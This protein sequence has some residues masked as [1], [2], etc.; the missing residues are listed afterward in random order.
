MPSYFESLSM[1]ALEAW[2]LGTP[3][4]RQREMRRAE[5]SVHPQQRRAVLRR[6]SRVRRN[7]ARDRAQSLAGRQPRQERPPVL[8][9]PLRLAGHR[10]EVSRHDRAAVE[11]RR[12]RERSTPV[13]GWFERRKV[14]C[15]PGAEVVA[16]LPSGPVDSA[17]A[18]AA[19]A[20]RRR[21]RR[22]SR[23]GAGRRAI[24]SIA[25]RDRR[26]AAVRRRR[27]PL[28]RRAAAR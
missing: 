26:H 13:P 25:S 6:P 16:A 15:P 18:Y 23:A 14:D 9:R 17:D 4:A 1:V 24:A 27:R 5:G 22:R 19:A 21:C 11:D 28:S 20:D 7:A 3:G 10:A 2:A 12:R 8:S